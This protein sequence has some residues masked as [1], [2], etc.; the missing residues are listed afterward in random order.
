M[1]KNIDRDVVI[2]MNRPLRFGTFTFYQMGYSGKPGDY[3]STIAIVKN[4]FKYMPYISSIIIVTGLFFHFLVKMWY[5]IS[6][7]GGVQRDE[8]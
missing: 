2:E 4:P 8:D 1:G 6:S 5:T 7:N 3:L